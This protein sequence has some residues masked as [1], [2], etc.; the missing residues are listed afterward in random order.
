MKDAIKDINNINYLKINSCHLIIS[1]IP[2]KILK[3]KEKEEELISK[4]NAILEILYLFKDKIN[5]KMIIDFIF[6]K[7]IE[8]DLP[9]EVSFYQYFF[10]SFYSFINIYYTNNQFVLIRFPQLFLQKDEIVY[11]YSIKVNLSNMELDLNQK[12]YIFNTS[13][14]DLL[15]IFEKIASQIDESYLLK[16]YKLFQYH[17]TCLAGTFDR[18]H[19][20]HYFLIQTSFLLSKYHCFIGVCSDEMIKHKCCFSL[21]QTNYVRRK[22]LEELVKINGFNNE[23]FKCDIKTIYDGVD[24]AGVE[25]NLDCLIVTSETYKGGLYCN[26]VRKKN[27]IKPVELCTINLIAINLDNM[28]KISSSILRN[29]IIERFPVEKINII[30]LV[31]QNLCINLKCEN[32]DLV[33]FWWNEILNNYTKKWKYYHNLNHIHSFIELFEKYNNIIEK[34]KNEFLLSIFFH[35]IIYIPSRNDN[36]EESIKLC[37]KFIQ[38]VQPQNLNKEKVN[39]F[40]METKNHLLNKDYGNDINLFMDMDMQ[41]IGQYNWEDYEKSIRK[42]YCFYDKN[43]YNIKRKEF[44]EKLNKKERIFR[45]DIFYKEFEKNA[46]TNIKNIIKTLTI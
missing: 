41:I 4:L 25:K 3:Y 30:Y 23:N 35:D 2:I 43:I 14:S 8:N 5:D 18:C 10:I 40:I 15:T 46:R 28:N 26:E 17:F 34:E 39:E 16:N 11:D 32:K 13:K 12:N 31:F 33:S 24:R 19:K 6:E 7:G 36:E 9:K 37:N 44:L 27:N 45:T 22:K 20:G 1:D 42:E 21:L 29:E 38:E